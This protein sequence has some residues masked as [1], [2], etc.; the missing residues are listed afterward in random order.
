MCSLISLLSA[1]A[2]GVAEKGITETGVCPLELQVAPGGT[3]EEV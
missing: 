1:E 2:L 3:V